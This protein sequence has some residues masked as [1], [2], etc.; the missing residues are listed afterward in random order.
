MG[1]TNVLLHTIPSYL[2]SKVLLKPVTS[3]HALWCPF[4]CR[5]NCCA[6]LDAVVA[7]VHIATGWRM[8]V[9]EVKGYGA[10]P[11]DRE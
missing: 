2:L 9:V 8:D 11:I 6:L 10:E 1:C 7:Q 5:P 3:P 4:V